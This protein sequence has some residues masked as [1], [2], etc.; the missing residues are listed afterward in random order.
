MIPKVGHQAIVRMC[1]S[2]GAMRLLRD[3]PNGVA[4]INGNP[5]ALKNISPPPPGAEPLLFGGL[6]FCD[7]ELLNCNPKLRSDCLFSKQNGEISLVHWAKKCM[8][9]PI[10]AKWFYSIYC[11]F[12]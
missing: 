12:L 2:A 7:P 11:A 1:S 10:L 9:V 6:Y 3:H 4:T 5:I 8:M